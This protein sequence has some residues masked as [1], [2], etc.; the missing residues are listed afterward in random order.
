MARPL[1][2]FMAPLAGTHLIGV[3][4]EVRENGGG[5]ETV[6][7]IHVRSMVHASFINKRE[8]TS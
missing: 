3:I 4:Q 2:L 8:L 6:A 7:V 5:G 1:G